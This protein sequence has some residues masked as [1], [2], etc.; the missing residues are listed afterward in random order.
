MTCPTA[1][2]E[3]NTYNIRSVDANMFNN[4]LWT[5][6]KMQAS[7]LG[8]GY[9]TT[10]CLQRDCISQNILNSFKTGHFLWYNLGQV[11]DMTNSGYGQVVFSCKQ[12]K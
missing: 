11:V 10:S 6:D 12:N 9:E 4:Q 1:V 2:D 7:H 3:W 5:A 8:V